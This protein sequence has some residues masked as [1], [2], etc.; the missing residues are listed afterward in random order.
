MAKSP[1]AGCASLDSAVPGSR[2][3]SPLSAVGISTADAPQAARARAQPDTVNAHKSLR[4]LMSTFPFPGV[5]R[6]LKGGVRDLDRLQHTVT[7]VEV[8][9]PRLRRAANLTAPQPHADGLP[10]GH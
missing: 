2:V 10:V 3:I 9:T 5:E 7:E 1:V 4:R 8:G 6:S